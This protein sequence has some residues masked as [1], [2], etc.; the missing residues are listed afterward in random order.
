[1]NRA[2]L[3]LIV[4]AAVGL[5]SS[6]QA[7]AAPASKSA[8]KPMAEPKAKA[9][10]NTRTGISIQ[11]KSALFGPYS[12][13]VGDGLNI[14][15]K[16]GFTIWDMNKPNEVNMLNAEN[17]VVF[18]DTA[19][20]WLKWNRRGVPLIKVS[21]VERVDKVSIAGQ[22]CVRYCGYQLVKGEKLKVA[23]FTCLQNSPI[24]QKVVD[25]WCRHF[26]I[27]SKYGFPIA[28]RQRVGDRLEIVLETNSIRVIPASTISVQVPKDYKETKDKANLYFADVGGGM[29][30][31]DFESFFQQPLK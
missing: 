16:F 24:N 7:S 25:F 19:A 30:K 27:P 22:P 9:L 11:G 12:M 20:G 5:A 31:S 29:S 2:F 14:R 21:E 4:G 6:T 28:V 13:Q 8:S 1:M 23:E 3:A 26:L 18:R 15:A 17:H 10:P